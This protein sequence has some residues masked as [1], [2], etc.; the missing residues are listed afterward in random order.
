MRVANIYQPQHYRHVVS[1]IQVVGQTET[2]LIQTRSSF[3]IFRTLVT[4]GD[5]VFFAGGRCDDLIDLQADEPRFARR[6]MI[7]D[8]RAV[9]TLMIIP[10]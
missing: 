2:G 5:S 3:A 8:S 7:Y 10:I 6:H 4:T 1:A 9:E